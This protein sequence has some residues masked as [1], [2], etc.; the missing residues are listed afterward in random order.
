MKP[1]LLGTTL[2]MISAAAYFLRRWWR[3]GG[4]RPLLL[5]MPVQRWPDFRKW[6]QRGEFK[7]NEAAALW[8]DAEPRSPMWWRARRKLRPLRVALADSVGASHPPP[9]TAQPAASGE[10]SPTVPRATLK[11]LAEKEGVQPLFLYPE[12]RF[13]GRDRD[14]K[15]DKDRLTSIQESTRS[16]ITSAQNELNGLRARMEDARQAAE[17]FTTVTGRIDGVLNENERASVEIRLLAAEKR[18]EQLKDHLAA[19]LRIESAVNEE[20]NF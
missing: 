8:F 3:Y 16:A 18:M 14:Q 4:G 9:R 5:H 7:L 10:V 11:V 2:L 20:L 12:F 17:A 6:D 1:W 19:L 13:R 15:T